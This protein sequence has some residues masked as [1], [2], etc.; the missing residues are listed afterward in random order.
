MNLFSRPAMANAL[1]LTRSGD[2]TAATREILAALSGPPREAPAMR[3][4]GEL[5]PDQLRI[6][7]GDTLRMA[8]P[9]P[10][11]TARF[12][13][14]RYCSDAGDLDYRLYIPASAAPGLPLLVMLHGCTQTPEDFARGTRMNRLADEHG[15]L[16]A[17]PEQ[18]RAANPQKCWNWFRSGDQHRDCGEPAML[19]NVVRQILADEG[20]DPTRVY[21]AGLSAGGAMAAILADA[22][23]DLFAAVGIHSGLP[24]GSARNVPGALS[25]MRSGGRGKPASKIFVPIIT[26]HGDRDQTVNEANNDAIV[27]AA[28]TLAGSQLTVSHDTDKSAS[29]TRS[30]REIQCDAAGA[31][32]IERWT[33][34]GAGHAWAGGDVTGTYT[35]ATGPDASKAMLRFFL[36][37]RRQ[38]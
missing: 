14:R 28:R 38:S 18:T 7:S 11:G 32:M 36:N 29:G 2:L 25:A 22:Y 26:I 19:A 27:A 37:H 24:A 31:I 15:L 5:I 6:G 4:G 10:D 30:T 1:R 34:H 12:E 23:P 33:V 16:V 35:D 20:A 8:P 21:A 17:Y 9:S 13:Q 3:D